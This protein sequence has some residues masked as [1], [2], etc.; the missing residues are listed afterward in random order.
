MKLLDAIS[1]HT[2]K[3]GVVGLGHVGLT[4]AAVF[5]DRGFTV[6]GCDLIRRLVKSIMYGN[7]KPFEPELAK[8]INN[9]VKSGKFSA[10]TDCLNV[11]ESCD[12]TIISAQTPVS[13]EHQ[14]D[15]SFLRSAC[16][17]VGHG[18]TKENLILIMSSIPPGTTTEMSRTL[19][20]ISGLS[21]G[22]DF[23]LSYCPERLA[24]G[25]SVRD[26][27]NNDRII[28]GFDA[29][30]TRL[31]S[32]LFQEVARGKVFL[33]D[34]LT[35]EIAKLAENTFR[36][37]NIA[38]A[39][40]L[41]LICEQDGADVQEVINVA[42]T[43]QRVNI[44]R[45]GSGVGGPCLP[46]DPYLLLARAK[47]HTEHSLIRC[48]RHLNSFMESHT[49][50]KILTALR[51]AKKDATGSRISVL[52]V[53]YK[54]GTSD[55]RGAPS[56][57]IIQELLRLGAQVNVYDPL[58]AESFNGKN[59]T[60]P[61]EAIA[62]TDCLV[63]LTDHNEFASLDLRKVKE[64]MNKPACI[65]DGRRVISPATAKSIGIRYYGVGFG[66]GNQI[67]H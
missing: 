18:L 49:L 55:I 21:C 64:T 15:L 33:T 65:V 38:F 66:K 63:I 67:H 50:S 41:A 54:K 60:G 28:G 29:Q 2:C 39:N 37:V 61:Y 9:A 1:K 32:H 27:I 12:I 13:K 24:P 46:K 40:E 5:A 45:P 59:C 6:S 47:Q 8:M 30:S 23:W 48:S 17:T 20:R 53:T 10:T 43:H 34:C 4:V 58:C 42:N 16:E 44:H 35:A 62:N 3:I 52:G 22:K 11:A 25:N 7:L 19:E 51:L 57:F 26:F 31:A 14:P 36:D 56:K